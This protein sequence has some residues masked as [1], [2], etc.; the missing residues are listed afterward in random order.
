MIDPLTDGL[1]AIRALLAD[2][3][4]D[5][6]AAERF[7]HAATELSLRHNIHGGADA[8]KLVA[9][10]R[11]WRTGEWGELD[12]LATSDLTDPLDV[13][14]SS[15]YF[16]HTGTRTLSRDAAIHCAGTM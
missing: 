8:T 14:A 7:T 16:A 15:L 13:I 11:A 6:S 2:W 5:F 10:T 3:T 12:H 4:G 9:F 1:L